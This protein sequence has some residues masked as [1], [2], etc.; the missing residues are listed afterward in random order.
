MTSARPASGCNSVARMR[1][2]VVL[3]AP[4]GPSSPKI[5][6]SGTSRST[7][8]SASVEPKFL[9]TPSTVM[10]DVVKRQPYPP[11]EGGIPG[12]AESDRWSAGCAFRREVCSH[13]CSQSAS[14]ADCRT[15]PET[16]KVPPQQ[17]LFDAAKRT[18]TS[19]GQS[20]HK[21]LNLADERPL[22][23]CRAV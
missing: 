18:R 7:P 10:A 12:G 13:G 3:P 1:T 21:A 9:V 20:P 4:F 8:A 6:P 17:D 11:W 23:A 5:A 19:T 14:P 2:S 22:A 16:E 15:G